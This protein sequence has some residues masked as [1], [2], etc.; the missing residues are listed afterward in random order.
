LTH[1]AVIMPKLYQLHNNIM[2]YVMG[3]SR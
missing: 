2:R 1:S 3:K